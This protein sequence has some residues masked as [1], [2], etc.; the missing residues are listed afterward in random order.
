[1]Y[2]EDTYSYNTEGINL[3]DLF[4]KPD[5]LDENDIDEPDL[6]DENDLENI[7]ISDPTLN[8]NES[9]DAQFNHSSISFIYYYL[10][11]L[12]SILFIYI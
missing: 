3:E 8:I 2:G 9:N 10:I 11:F 1:V 5:P 6:L 12:I 7:T 4:I